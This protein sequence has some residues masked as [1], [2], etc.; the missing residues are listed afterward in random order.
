MA[1]PTYLSTLSAN[2]KAACGAIIIAGL[3]I[4][5][6]IWQPWATPKYHEVEEETSRGGHITHECIAYKGNITCEW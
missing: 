5:L 6:A 3:L 4:A 1:T 2:T